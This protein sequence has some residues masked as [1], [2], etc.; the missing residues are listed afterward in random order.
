MSGK[1]EKHPAHEPD[2]LR[3]RQLEA[4]LQ[5]VKAQLQETIERYE[6]PTEE[7]RAVKDK[8]A[9]EELRES[10]ERFKLSAEAGRIGNWQI[11]LTRGTLESSAICKANFGLAANEDLSFERLFEL[12]HPDDRDRLRATLK[13]AVETRTD[14]DAEY[15]VLWSDNSVHWIFA[16]GRAFYAADG[17]PL[18]MLGV[19]QNITERK[20]SEQA[21]RESEAKYH[22]LFDSIDEGFCLIEMILDARGEPVDYRFLE[23]NAAFDRQNEFTGVVGKTVLELVPDIEKH[24]LETY[25]RVARTGEAVRFENN[26]APINRWLDIYAV[27]VGAGSRQIAVVF[28]DI[29]ERKRAEE[30]LRTSEEWLRQATEAGRVFVWEVDLLKQT[31]K[32]SGNV[33][34]VL[35]FGLPTNLEDNFNA[36]HP[37][38]RERQREIVER[39]IATGGR[40]D[41]EHRISNPS[42][43]ASVWVRASG[44][45]V[46]GTDSEPARIVGMTQNITGRKQAEEA[47]REA[48]DDLERRVAERTEQLSIVN[49]DLKKEIIER[50]RVEEERRQLLHRILFAQEDER[51]RIARDLHDQ[52]GQQVTTLILQLSLLKTANRVTEAQREHISILETIAKQFDAD[53]DFLVRELLPTALDDLGLQSA[54]TSHVK[55]WSK[56]S[57]VPAEFHA[58][59]ME[60][61][62]LTPEIETT[63]YRIVQEAL[64]NVAKH[65]RAGK[66]DVL[67]ERRA[68]SV[69]LIIEDNGVGFDPAKIHGAGNGGFGLTGMRERAALASGTVVIEA[70]PGKGVTV[71]AR[72]PAP[73]VT[74]GGEMA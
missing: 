20:Q 68:D 5:S 70:R 40:F 58:S 46:N 45:V 22:S 17:T 72:I 14:Y 24:W 23:T 38:D 74:S 3:V 32:F 18:R 51:R 7:P 42:G 11:D 19:T 30:R 16:R 21:L 4:E 57:G 1:A 73:H 13:K 67:I 44:A 33:E 52:F 63:L 53:I 65:A 8:L 41:E 47:L 39:A 29:T 64:N 69:S 43:G 59:G 15:R 66:V 37:E 60:K 56:H 49:E 27:R 62:R 28:R 35:G 71:I 55:A 10:E 31:A 12:L 61:D 36:L 6:T 9:A 2:A 48:R 26:V 50:K 34:R 25:G 54:L